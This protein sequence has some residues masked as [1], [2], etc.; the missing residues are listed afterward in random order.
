MK[1]TQIILLLSLIGGT[2]YNIKIPMIRLL[3]I[4]FWMLLPF[5][6]LLVSFKS[7]YLYKKIFIKELFISIF[8]I[9]LLT[10][11]IVINIDTFKIGFSG[12]QV[13]MWTAF[14]YIFSSYLFL[15]YSKLDKFKI[16]KNFV[17]YFFVIVILFLFADMIIRYIQNPGCFLNYSCRHDS[18]VLGLFMNSNITGQITAF[19]IVITWYIDLKYKKIFQILLLWFLFAALARSAWIA[20]I[21]TYV[22][23]F[24]I[25][26][27]GLIKYLLFSLGFLIIL[28]FFIIDPLNLQNDGSGLSKLHFFIRTYEIIQ[29]SNWLHIFFGF[30]AS[31]EAISNLLNMNGWSPHVAILKAFLYYGII[32]LIIYFYILYRLVKFDKRMKLPILVY[33]IFSL[34]GGP[35]YWPTLSVGL[36]IL[37]IDDEIKRKY[38]YAN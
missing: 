27:K 25:L 22:I 17:F 29:E 26:R 6:F 3:L 14:L 38:N 7:K 15:Y 8:L 13:E 24:V 35:I 33:V 32:G 16:N 1:F 31:F 23:S 2:V 36:V 9:L 10:F 34:A 18:K 28:L 12:P 21:L 11:S 19:L 5:I 30:G 4:S 37:L 20:L